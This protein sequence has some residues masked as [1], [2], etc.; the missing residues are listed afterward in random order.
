MMKK[1]TKAK[2]PITQSNFHNK[3]N[4]N[5]KTRKQKTLNQSIVFEEIFS[6]CKQSKRHQWHKKMFTKQISVSFLQVSSST[7]KS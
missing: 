1:Q 3:N 7:L 2:I 5:L 6:Y 4:P